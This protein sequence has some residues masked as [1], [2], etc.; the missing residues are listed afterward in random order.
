MGINRVMLH[1]LTRDSGLPFRVGYQIGTITFSLTPSRQPLANSRSSTSASGCYPSFP[2]GSRSVFAN[3]LSTGSPSGIQMV[4][5]SCCTC[6]IALLDSSSSQQI[7][8]QAPRPGSPL[9]L[10]IRTPA[11]AFSAGRISLPASP[12]GS[13]FPVSTP[14]L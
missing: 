3:F 10:I 9:T 4:Y 8:S 1:L 13:A 11:I 6:E 12:T 5:M 2:S 7:G 14:I